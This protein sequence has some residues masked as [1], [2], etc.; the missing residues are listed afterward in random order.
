MDYVA[1]RRNMVE[2][3]IRPNKVTDPMVVQALETVP[4]EMFVPKHMRGIAYTDD[5]LDL[6][7]GRALMEPMVLARL[8]QE[9]RIE[10]EE[11]A[12]VVGCGTG[13]SAAVL[14]RLCSTVVALES[15]SEFGARAGAIMGELGYDNVAVVPGTLTAGCPEQAPYNII[16]VDGAIETVPQALL[17]QLADGGRLIAVVTGH[18]QG[19][20]TICTRRGDSWGHLGV[21]DANIRPLPGFAKPPAFTF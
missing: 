12:L 7:G 10:E 1:A 18:G 11:I 21:F 20:G 5:D 8:L 9:A 13:Y 3:Q 15:D 19:V 17:D 2:G 4:R 14:S 6:G 16:L